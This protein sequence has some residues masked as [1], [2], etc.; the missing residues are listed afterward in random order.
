MVI[1]LKAFLGLSK[2]GA[3]RITALCSTSLSSLSLRWRCYLSHLAKL[4]LSAHSFSRE[5]LFS[6]SSQHPKNAERELV[7]VKPGMVIILIVMF[8][9][10]ADGC[11]KSGVKTNESQVQTQ[12][13]FEAEFRRE[14]EMQA[15][16]DPIS[17]EFRLIREDLSNHNV[18]MVS[19]SGWTVIF[20][21]D[22]AGFLLWDPVDVS[23]RLIPYE[24]SKRVSNA[25]VKVRMEQVVGGNLIREVVKTPAFELKKRAEP[26]WETTIKN[27]FNTKYSPPSISTPK[28]AYLMSVEVFFS[29]VKIKIPDIPVEFRSKEEMMTGTNMYWKRLGDKDFF[30][31]IPELQPQFSKK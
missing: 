22:G 1:Y 18:I 30:E 11:K 24:A 23:L 8:L 21:M 7:F 17:L 6:R 28:G 4:K 29:G 9:M 13:E 5:L 3:N 26:G 15:E 20:W 12:A 31:F 16:K 2:R 19:R 25:K 10:C 27:V 14:I